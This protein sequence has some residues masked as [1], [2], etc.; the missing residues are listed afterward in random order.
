M[1][2]LS[3]TLNIRNFLH[4]IEISIVIP[5]SNAEVSTHSLVWILIWS[6]NFF[7]CFLTHLTHLVQ[8]AEN[9]C[10]KHFL[11]VKS[12]LIRQIKRLG[13]VLD[14]TSFIQKCKFD[15]GHV[16]GVKY[17]KNFARDFF[18]F[19]YPSD[20]FRLPFPITAIEIKYFILL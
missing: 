8:H 2:G 13:S 19:F 9:L 14:L 10:N 4:L 15:H 1:S 7:N 6:K 11:R 18:K 20:M 12:K 5:I 16:W 17:S 3:K